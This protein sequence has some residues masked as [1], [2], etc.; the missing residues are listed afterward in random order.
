MFCDFKMGASKRV[1]ES[2]ANLLDY[3]QEERTT[4]LACQLR[5][6]TLC[7]CLALGHDANMI[8]FWIPSNSLANIWCFIWEL[9]AQREGHWMRESGWIWLCRLES[10][11]V[12]TGIA[13]ITHAGASLKVDTQHLRDLSLRPGS[14][15]Q[16]IGELCVET[17]NQ[18]R[19][20]LRLS[21]SQNF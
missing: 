21:H 10:Y 4:I 7:W 12:E 13:L 14:L 3:G 16:F 18:V 5:D 17:P 2:L 1:I 20:N 11:E 9:Q 15:Y 19:Q 6:M 8:F